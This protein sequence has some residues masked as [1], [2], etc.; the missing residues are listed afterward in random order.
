VE[1]PDTSSRALFEA[2]VV[3]AEDD[4]KPKD[5]LLG[6][7]SS[8]VSVHRG[9]F[10]PYLRRK[11]PAGEFDI[12]GPMTSTGRLFVAQRVRP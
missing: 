1:S 3:L 12:G 8:T 9:S 6:Y 4:A 5:G 10:D 11:A 7:T 2:V